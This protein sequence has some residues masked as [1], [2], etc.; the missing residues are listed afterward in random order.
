MNRKEFRALWKEMSEQKDL[1][2]KILLHFK[3][4]TLPEDIPSAIEAFRSPQ[5]S[6][7]DKRIGII[8]TNRNRR[9]SELIEQ[10]KDN[11]AKLLA[12][13]F[14]HTSLDLRLEDVYIINKPLIIE[15][16]EGY[17]IYEA[18]IYKDIF[19]DYSEDHYNSIA[20]DIELLLTSTTC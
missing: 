19:G 15:Y 18:S 12:L 1:Y 7:K 14:L 6:S 3:G 17:K 11:Y 10:F 20:G 5:I 4:D 13:G 2:I 8:I 9:F 16:F